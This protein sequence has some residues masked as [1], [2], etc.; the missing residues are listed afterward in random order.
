MPISALVTGPRLAVASR[1]DSPSSLMI[2]TFS[3]TTMGVVNEQPD[4]EP[5]SRTLSACFWRTRTLPGPQ[6]S[7][8]DEPEPRLRGSGYPQIAHEQVHLQEV[9]RI[10][11]TAS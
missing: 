7:Q 11:S 1:G 6:T 9:S 8:D 4:G 3:T 2:F 5:P 10:A